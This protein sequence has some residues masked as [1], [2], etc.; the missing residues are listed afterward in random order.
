MA[1]TNFILGLLPFCF[2]V[3]C[4]IAVITAVLYLIIKQ[5]VKNAIRDILHEENF[6]I[7]EN[8]E[9]Q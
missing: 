6:Q 5:A 9:S 3:I 7:K 2:A 4:I 8:S 1:I